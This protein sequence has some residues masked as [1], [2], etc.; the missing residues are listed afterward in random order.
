V[1]HLAT[2]SFSGGGAL[3]SVG[4]HR[5]LAAWVNISILFDNCKHYEAN[6]RS[7]ADRSLNG[8]HRLILD[9]YILQDSRSQ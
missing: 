9:L 2:C 4:L 8:V 5:R 7:V 6:A 3:A 1:F